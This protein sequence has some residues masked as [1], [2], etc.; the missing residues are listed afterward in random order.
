MKINGIYIS[1]RALE[2]ADRIEMVTPEE[3][4]AINCGLHSGVRPCCVLFFMFNHV[5]MEQSGAKPNDG[6]PASDMMH[7]YHGE[8]SHQHP[9]DDPCHTLCPYCVLNNHRAWKLKACNCWNKSPDEM[10]YTIKN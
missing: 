4:Y 8:I 7:K 2:L 10:D 1:H 3:I 9:D 6:S 5:F